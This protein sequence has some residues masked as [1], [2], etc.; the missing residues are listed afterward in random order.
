MFS[1]S[2]MGFLDFDTTLANFRNWSRRGTSFEEI[3]AA[4]AFQE[5]GSDATTLQKISQ[6]GLLSDI[7]YDEVLTSYNANDNPTTV[8]YKQAGVTVATLTLTYTG[9]NLTRIV[10]S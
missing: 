1:S 9:Q 10:R 7:A 6:K 2:L 8:V 5:G 3:Q 4:I